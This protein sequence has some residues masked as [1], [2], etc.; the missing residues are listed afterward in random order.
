MDIDRHTNSFTSR[1]ARAR[2]MIPLTALAAVMAACAPSSTLPE[3]DPMLS[4]VEG[5]SP[6]YQLVIASDTA[7]PGFFPA[8][9]EST[10]TDIYLS[11]DPVDRV[12]E[13]DSIV[14]SI[15]PAGLHAGL[16]LSQENLDHL[17]DLTEKHVGKRIAFQ[18]F[19]RVLTASQITR[20][21]R[22][23]SPVIHLGM[24]LPDSSAN[25]MMERMSQTIEDRNH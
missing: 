11:R 15:N 3:D 20:P 13:F 12:S 23:D 4:Y 25:D 22:F 8:T 1:L 17:S 18:A 5:V 14:P 24:P 10:N 9:L 7:L 6:L 16:W 2:F 19:G 21:I